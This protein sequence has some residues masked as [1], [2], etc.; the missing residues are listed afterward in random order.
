MQALLPLLNFLMRFEFLRK[1]ILEAAITPI[2][3]QS[4]LDQFAR[5]VKAAGLVNLA[6]SIGKLTLVVHVQLVP[7]RD[8]QKGVEL[9]WLKRGSVRTAKQLS[10]AQKQPVRVAK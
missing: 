7:T 6:D 10:E 1:R 3:I 4:E 8:I 9:V 5:N 2:R